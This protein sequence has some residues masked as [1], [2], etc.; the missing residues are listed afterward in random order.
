MNQREYPHPFSVLG[1][2]QNPD[3]GE[4]EEYYYE[5]SAALPLGR[6]V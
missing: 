6:L 1:P 3:S 5:L 2:L 4:E